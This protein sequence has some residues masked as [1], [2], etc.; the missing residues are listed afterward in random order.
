MQQNFN[1]F[2]L[3]VPPERRYGRPGFEQTLDHW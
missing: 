2:D 3:L 1:T